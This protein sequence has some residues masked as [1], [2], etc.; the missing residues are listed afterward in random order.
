MWFNPIME[1]LLKSP[2]HGML[3]GNTMIL[4]YTGRKSG[5]AYHVP[6]GYLCVNGTLLTVS[7]KERTW[8]R[9][10]RSGADVT[11]LLKGK[12]VPAHAQ[13]V[14]DD[15]GVA[16]GLKEFIG[17][18]PQAAHMFGVNLDANGQ[19]QLESLQQAASK[20]VIVRTSL[21]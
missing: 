7:S 9:N 13:A 18:T 17:E 10:L 15:L 16:D 4:H 2:L 6:V 19:P 20:R 8:W 21:R 12:I 3:S 11:V 14:E 5:K 1:W